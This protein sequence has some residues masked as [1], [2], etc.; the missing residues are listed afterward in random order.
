MNSST[1]AWRDLLI[2]ILDSNHCRKVDEVLDAEIWYN[3]S[4]QNLSGF[5]VP[6]F[7][8]TEDT[9]IEVLR[10]AELEDSYVRY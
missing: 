10:Q 9:L 7:I 6:D 4:S 8:R 3:P 1:S 2:Q 5:R